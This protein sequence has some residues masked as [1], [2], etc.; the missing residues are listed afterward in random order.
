MA[1]G[2]RQTKG[3]QLAELRARIAGLR[4]PAFRAR[5]AQNLGEE[6]RTQIADEFRAERDPYGKPWKPLKYRKGKI[7]RKT[8][9]MA[10]SVAVQPLAG[11]FRVDIPV[12]YAP[13]H[14]DGGKDK[15]GNRTHPPQRQMLPEEETGG[16]GPIWSKAFDAVTD[17]VI[18]KHMQGK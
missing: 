6:A 18:R 12:D 11:G 16:L 4:D 14:Q 3:I 8:G 5:L 17:D 10:G 1:G 2:A 7:L 9:R 15:D 13:P